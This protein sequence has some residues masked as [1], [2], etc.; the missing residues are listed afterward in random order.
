M[1]MSNMSCQRSGKETWKLQASVSPSAL[2][3]GQVMFCNFACWLQV[4]RVS[5]TMLDFLWIPLLHHQEM[6]SFLSFVCLFVLER[7]DLQNCKSWHLKTSEEVQVCIVGTCMSTSVRQGNTFFLS[8]QRCL[9]QV[10]ATENQPMCFAGHRNKIVLLW[11]DTT[12]V[13]L[14]IS[15]LNQANKKQNWICLGFLKRKK[16]S[17][18]ESCDCYKLYTTDPSAGIWKGNC[19]HQFITLRKK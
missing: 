1:I 6:F 4:E 5:V 3:G 17:S 15:Q 8:C 7:R 19:P 10:S 14:A 12:L 16:K 11:Y 18:P 9:A 13:L 2:F